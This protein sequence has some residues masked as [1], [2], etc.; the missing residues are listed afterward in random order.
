MSSVGLKNV[1]HYSF[2]FRVHQ[3]QRLFVPTTFLILR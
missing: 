3:L 1:F 2:G